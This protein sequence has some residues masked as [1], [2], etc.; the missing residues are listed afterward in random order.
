MTCSCT[1]N[2]YCETAQELVER[3]NKAYE[4]WRDNGYREGFYRPYEWAM[5]QRRE[6]R[7]HVN[8]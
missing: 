3:E 8:G 6:H 7:S 1:L 2:K 5:E 4:D